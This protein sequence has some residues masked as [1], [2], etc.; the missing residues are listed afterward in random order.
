M[1]QVEYAQKAVDNSGSVIAVRCTDGV[2]MGVEKLLISKMLVPGTGR[3]LHTIDTHVGMGTAGLVPDGRAFA[4]LA[5]SEARS[6]RTNYGMP[7]PPKVLAE[8]MAAQAWAHTAGQ[9]RPW[10]CSAIIIGR[11]ADTEQCELYMV[12]PSGV[13]F[14][15]FGCAA[16]KGRQAAKTEIEKN[17]LFDKSCAEVINEI[18]KT[19][20]TLHDELKD[21][22]F[23][24]ELSWVCE[25]SGW[26]HALVPNDQRDA[27]VAWA[28]AKIEEEEMEDDSDEDDDEDE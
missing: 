22:P 16:G 20:H 13:N 15:Y 21:K 6:Y 25:A 4:N 3:R 7:I 18:A 23:E 1:F 26:K 5:R 28:K 24:L 19:L 10:G 2:V 12:E 9:S 8:R 27:A 17:K 14:R 11:D